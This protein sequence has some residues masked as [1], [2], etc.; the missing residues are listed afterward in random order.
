MATIRITIF[1]DNKRFRES[2][3]ILFETSHGFELAGSFPDVLNV[4][5]NVTDSKP[6]VVLMDI[7]MPGINGISGKKR[8]R[9]ISRTPHHHA[10]QF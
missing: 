4:V 1:D 8:A 2:I 6:D 10:H 3:G 7:D 5:E 9:K